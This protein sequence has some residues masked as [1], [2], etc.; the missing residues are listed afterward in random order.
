[1]F[2]VP[3]VLD[4]EILVGLA[5]NVYDLD[6]E[7]LDELLLDEYDLPD[8]EIDT[9]C[10]LTPLVVLTTKYVLRDDELVFDVQVTVISFP[11]LVTVQ[12]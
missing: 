7:L 10:S 3:A 6:E 9:R 5:D 8:C 2:F 4:T 12:N 1:M 11:L